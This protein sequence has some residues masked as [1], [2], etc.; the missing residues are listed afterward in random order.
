M[1]IEPAE[2]IVANA[3]ASGFPLLSEASKMD[4]TLQL[5][6]DAPSG[7]V[8][9]RNYTSNLA[10]VSTQLRFVHAGYGLTLVPKTTGT[11]R[12]IATMR[13]RFT[14]TKT[15]GQCV[16]FLQYG[17]GSVPVYQEARKGTQCPGTPDLSNWESQPNAWMSRPYLSVVEGL[18]V[19]QQYWF[20]VIIDN[21]NPADTSH[22][23]HANIVVEELE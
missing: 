19:G 5:L 13:G 2:T 9:N 4:V 23:Q 11:V 14:G 20:D 10:T 8:P 18:T 6:A 22:I 12:V 16:T 7:A 1:A 21:T 3:T 17:D 15:S